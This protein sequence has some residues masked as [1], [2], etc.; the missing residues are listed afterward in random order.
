[1]NEYAAYFEIK[2]KGQTITISTDEIYYVGA[3]GDYV[4]LQT[5]DRKYLYR[6]TLGS[7]S[8]MLDPKE[9]V[10]IHR[11]FL[12]NAAYIRSCRYLSN[13]EF[14]FSFK[15]DAELISGRAFKNNIKE[16]LE[17]TNKSLN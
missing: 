16:F 14:L 8:E 10:R 7:L 5:K 2:E 15:N 12:I 4:A 6:V 1:M 11:S 9:F 3:N 17:R 13:N